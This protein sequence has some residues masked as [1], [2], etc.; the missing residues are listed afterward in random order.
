MDKQKLTVREKLSQ[1]ERIRQVEEKLD[2]IGSLLFDFDKD[3]RHLEDVM[4]QLI[5]G[6]ARNSQAVAV[7]SD[8]TSS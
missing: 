8:E 6:L 5:V 4:R 3:I 2:R 1:A 7:S